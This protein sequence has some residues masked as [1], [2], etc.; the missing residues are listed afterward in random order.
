[1][2]KYTYKIDW[3]GRIKGTQTVIVHANGIE[4]AGELASFTEL[5]EPFDPLSNYNIEICD[6]DLYCINEEPV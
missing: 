5:R 2:K 3:S 1:M 6:T 4:E